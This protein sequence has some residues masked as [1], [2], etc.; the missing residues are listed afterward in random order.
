[1]TIAEYREFVIKHLE[2]ITGESIKQSPDFWV[3]AH[4][5]GE[6]QKASRIVA[7]EKM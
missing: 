4:A 3:I 2:T 5:A 6:I 7:Q 1:M